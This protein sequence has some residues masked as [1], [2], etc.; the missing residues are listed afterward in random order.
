MICGVFQYTSHRGSDHSFVPAS[1]ARHDP[2]VSGAPLLRWRLYPT[3]RTRVI[4]GLRQPVLTI[5]E[6]L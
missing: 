4:E 6:R 5:P 2:T 1:E 3:S